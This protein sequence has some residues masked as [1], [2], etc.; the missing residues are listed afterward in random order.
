MRRITAATRS[1]SSS[2]ARTTISWAT[3]PSVRDNAYVAGQFLWTGIDYLGEAGVFPNRANGAGL[4]DLCGF[5]KPMAWFRQSLWSDAPMV[6][7]AA[8]VAPN[9][10]TAPAGTGA[11][12]PR[13]GSRV[14]E[15][16]NWAAGATVTVS[17]YTNCEDVTLTLND[18]PLGVKPLAGAADGVL[19]WDVPYQPGVLRAVGRVK[20]KEAAEFALTTADAPARVELVPDVTRLGADGEDACHIEYRIVDKRGVRVP[21]AD[22]QVTFEVQGPARMLGIGNGDLNDASS[23]QDLVHRAYQ[24]RG[25]AILQATG[26]P[27]PIMVRASAPGLEPASVTLTAVARV[28]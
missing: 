24:G 19:R 15:H 22:A 17:C 5:K 7:L 25:L 11:A 20:G 16:W 8:A 28:K 14:E 4:L 23:G 10:A 6:Y 2:A 27:G 9:P 21:N 26:A 3:G 12:P 18:Q 13:R 1:A